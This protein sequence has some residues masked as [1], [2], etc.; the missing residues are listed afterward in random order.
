MLTAIRSTIG[1]CFPQRLSARQSFILVFLISLFIIAFVKRGQWREPPYWDAAFSVFPAAITLTQTGFDYPALLS[2][3]T[4]LD[5]GPNVHASS[6]IALLTAIALQ[7]AGDPSGAYLILHWIHYSIAAL[8]IALLY[9]WAVP[10]LGKPLG[11]MVA[12]GMLLSPLYLTQAGHMYLELP[13]AC[14][15]LLAL[16]ACDARRM[17]HASC[18]ALLAVSIKEPGLIVAGTLVVLIALDH[19]PIRTRLKRIAI[20]VVPSIMLAAGQLMLHHSSAAEKVSFSRFLEGVWLYLSSAPDVLFIFVA[21]VLAVS[22]H[23]IQMLGSREQRTGSTAEYRLQATVV[24]AAMFAAFYLTLAALGWI[25]ILLRYFLIV[26]PFM[27]LLC[28]DLSKRIVG[29]RS[30]V[31]GLML[32]CLISIVN[33]NG[34]FYHYVSGN[35]GAMAERS[36]EYVD[37]LKVH[38]DSMAAAEKL[39]TDVP[40]FHGLPEHYFSQYPLMGYVQFPLK[41]AHCIMFESRYSNADLSTFPDHFYLLYSYRSLGGD[42]LNWLKTQALA[43]PEYSIATSVFRHGHYQAQLIEIRRKDM[44]S[45]HPPTGVP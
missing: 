1:S 41:N 40:I 30:T 18:W 11:I 28:A 31:L 45:E 23:S 35:N 38:Q 39:P 7:I 13:M 10:V 21:A 8:T 5:G 27:I 4:Y 14:A 32:F 34:R 37:L 29:E 33:H 42:K 25:F 20:V 44:P 9:L 16:L 19:T 6:S 43:N 36:N 24:I 15:A 2:A 12:G 22:H 3:P 17:V 26:L